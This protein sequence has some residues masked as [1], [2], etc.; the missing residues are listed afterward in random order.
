M[1][2]RSSQQTN[3]DTI[4]RTVSNSHADTTTTGANFLL[5]AETELT[6]TVRPFSDAYE[7]MKSIPIVTAATAYDEIKTG[8]TIIL[9]FHQTLWF[10]QALMTSL[11][12]PQQVR[13]YGL[14]FCDDPYDPN[15]QIGIHDHETETFIP[16]TVENS[17]VG[18][19]TRRPTL[20]EYET[21]RHVIMTSD[22]PW[23]PSSQRLPHNHPRQISTI[24]SRAQRLFDYPSEFELVMNSCSTALTDTSLSSQL[25]P[26]SEISSITSK[27]RHTKITAEELA[28][29]F[30]IGLE[31]AR[32][33]LQATTQLGMRSSIH[34][35]VRRYR[36]DLVRGLEARRI[37]DKWYTDTFFSRVKS[38]SGH[39]CGQL[40]TNTNF[41]SVHP[42]TCGPGARRL[43]GGR[44]DTIPSCF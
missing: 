39:T 9:V 27:T 17:M 44:R 28:R 13:S 16:F 33:T 14:S 35:I 29:K 11:I 38:I 22:Q 25:I 31:T 1:S 43:Y 19:T 24:T 40:F 7:E 21:C 37:P 23:D 26:P 2:T 32:K 34:P 6:C 20:T 42:V 8:T 10:G 18:V 5:V 12:C 36:T 3:V 41:V 30:K 4:G 15:R